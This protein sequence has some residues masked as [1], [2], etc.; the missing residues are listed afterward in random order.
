VQVR[1]GNSLVVRTVPLEEYVAAA[2][3]SEIDP[4]S[5]DERALERMFEVQAIVARTYAVANTGRHR[6]AGFDLCS[7]TH[8]QLY[9]PARLRGSQWASIAREAARRTEGLI[10]AFNGRPARVVF[11]ADCGGHTTSASA[12][13]GGTPLPYLQGEADDGPAK[14]VHASWTFTARPADLRTALD[15]DSR[16]A[17]GA[18]LDAIRIVTR[19][20][21][22]RA[23]RIELRGTRTMNVSG[24]TFREVVSRRM[25]VRTLRST[26]FT[27]RQTRDGFVFAGRGFGHGVGLCQAG[28][29]ARIKAGGTPAEVL[30]FY[31]PGTRVV[32]LTGPGPL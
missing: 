21:S 15:G 2:V 18:R 20:G 12:L 31:F 14:S 10:L 4:P 5:A 13:W 16:T 32:G 9:E 19:D 6:S 28:A 8:C 27:V 3:L 23:A 25:G 17:I 29:F 30:V 1:E 26:L 11:H 7:T 22:G 24:E